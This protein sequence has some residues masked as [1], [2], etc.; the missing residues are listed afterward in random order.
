MNTKLIGSFSRTKVGGAV[1]AKPEHWVRG[2]SVFICD[3]ELNKNNNECEHEQMNM[4]L[5]HS[6]TSEN[7][8]R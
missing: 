2:G 7:L 5:L 6:V 1:E 8:Q 4:R 3:N